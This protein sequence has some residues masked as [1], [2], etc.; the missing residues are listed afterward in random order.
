MKLTSAIYPMQRLAVKPEL[1]CIWHVSVRNNIGFD[2]WV[3]MD[4]EYIYLQNGIINL[5]N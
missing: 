3:E 4:I 5:S 1:T 2:E